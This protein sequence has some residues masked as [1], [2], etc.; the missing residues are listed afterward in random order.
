MIHLVFAEDVDRTRQNG[1]LS[2][3]DRDVDNRYVER[4]L[5]SKNCTYT[6]TYTET[7]VWCTLHVLDRITVLRATKKPL[8]PLRQL[9]CTKIPPLRLPNLFVNNILIMLKSVRGFEMLLL[10]TVTT[11]S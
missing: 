1:R 8:C 6:H 4:R 10:L 11:C 2:C 3:H 9:N 5:Q 7:P